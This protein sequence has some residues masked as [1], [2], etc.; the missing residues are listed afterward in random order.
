M[1]V[2]Y[3][4]WVMSLVVRFISILSHVIG[5]WLVARVRIMVI[6]CS[7]EFNV[8]IF[9]DLWLGWLYTL[10]SALAIISCSARLKT[11]TN[12]LLCW[13]HCRTLLIKLRVDVLIDQ[14]FHIL[15]VFFIVTAYTYVALILVLDAIIICCTYH[16]IVLLSLCSD[17]RVKFTSVFEAGM[18]GC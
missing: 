16:R 5:L 8:L 1:L 14:V 11:S 10:V 18:N 12:S 4:A 2:S 6:L 3:V 9:V 17:K 7:I 15:T 13:Y